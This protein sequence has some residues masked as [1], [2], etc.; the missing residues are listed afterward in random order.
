M[1]ENNE[2]LAKLEAKYD[3]AYDRKDALAEQIESLRK[4]ILN[5]PDQK[6]KNKMR[7]KRDQLIN[8]RDSIII[9]EDTVKIPMAPKT[10]KI[11]TAVVA[12]ILVIALLF[13]YVA[14]SFILLSLLSISAFISSDLSANIFKDLTTS[15][16]PFI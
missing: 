3:K 7:A 2:K 10:K 15:F 14:V 6:K 13:T 11:I 5:E 12:V 8:E 1:A 9:T 16:A 4:D